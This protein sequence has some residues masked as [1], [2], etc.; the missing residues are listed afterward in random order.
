M[1]TYGSY[2]EKR[3]VAKLA[4]VRQELPET[5]VTDEESTKIKMTSCHIECGAL[6]IPGN[7]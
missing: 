2:V 6:A 4:I 1:M 7:E 5:R 3:I